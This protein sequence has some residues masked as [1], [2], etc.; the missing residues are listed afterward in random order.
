MTDGLRFLRLVEKTISFNFGKRL[1]YAFE[2]N[3]FQLEL[4]ASS[5][6]LLAASLVP[7]RYL[8]HHTEYR[9]VEIIDHA[10]FE[11]DD[12]IIGDVNLLGTNLGAALGDVAQPDAKFVLE[13]FR[14]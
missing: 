13:Q 4:H 10:L 9:I 2:G 7:S 12:R 3:G 8:T 14:P 6:L 5:F 1:V 11:R